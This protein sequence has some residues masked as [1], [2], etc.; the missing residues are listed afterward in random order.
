MV[1]DHQ[2]NAIASCSINT[3]R[4]DTGEEVAI[5]LAITGTRARVIVSDSKTALRNYARGTVSTVAAHILRARSEAITRQVRL[6]W[7]PA[8]SS[9]PGNEMA[10]EAA[11]GLCNQADLDSEEVPSDTGARDRLWTY[12][13]ITQHYK[14]S[15]LKLPAAHISLTRGQ[16][17]AWRRLQTYTFPHPALCH[18][19]YPDRFKGTCTWCGLSAASL[20]HMVWACNLKPPPNNQGFHI[21]D[22]EQWEAALLSPIPEVQVAVVQ[23]AEDA[24]RAHGLLAVV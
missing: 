19:Q 10:H 22:Y 7:T 17:V 9:L 21:N 4:P 3:S 24:A 5:A 20:T 1:V 13:E 6:I 14:L 8:H 2:G 12:Q 23:L 11:R 15:R 16:S 18:R